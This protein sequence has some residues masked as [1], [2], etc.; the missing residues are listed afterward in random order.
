MPRCAVAL[1]SRF[2]NGMFVAWHGCGIACVNQTRPHCVNQ[3]GR[4]QSK[5]LAARHGNGVVCVKWP[6]F[7]CRF[8]S[9]RN[10]PLSRIWRARR[11]SEQGCESKFWTTAGGSAGR[12]DLVHNKELHGLYCSCSRVMGGFDGRETEIASDKCT[13]NFGRKP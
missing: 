11:V 2:H 8:V 13:P 5:L 9:M 6:L 3:M 12:M 7:A 4:T 10:T 1:R